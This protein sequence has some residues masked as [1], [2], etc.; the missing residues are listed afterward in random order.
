MRDYVEIYK[1]LRQE[2]ED[3][4]KCINEAEQRRR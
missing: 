1:A 3:L 4:G 2:N